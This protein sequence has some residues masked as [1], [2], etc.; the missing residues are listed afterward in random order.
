MHDQGVDTADTKRREERITRWLPSRP[1]RALALALRLPSYIYR[2]RLGGLLGHRFLLLTHR[3]RKSGLTRRTP[4][5]VLHYVRTLGR[6][7]SSRP[8]ARKRLVP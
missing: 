8:G 3:R 7:S 2:L 5:E 1:S 6:A 4:L